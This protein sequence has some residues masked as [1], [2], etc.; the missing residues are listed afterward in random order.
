M[1]IKQNAPFTPN[2]LTTVTEPNLVTVDR[3]GKVADKIGNLAVTQGVSFTHTLPD[4]TNFPQV[5]VLSGQR[6]TASKCNLALLSVLGASQ[7]VLTNI[8]L[9]NTTS[10]TADTLVPSLSSGVL[11][12]TNQGTN[13][14]T[15]TVDV[16][17]HRLF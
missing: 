8:Q 15:E 2:P 17:L 10:T 12:I 13:N 3:S 5:Y 14:S 9:T 11:T 6:A 4:A 1:A 16:Y 7:L